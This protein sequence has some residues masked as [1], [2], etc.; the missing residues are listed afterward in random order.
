M[1]TQDLER[2]ELTSFPMPVTSEETPSDE[3]LLLMTEPVEEP[4]PY[5]EVLELRIASL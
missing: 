1:L 4:F 5:E 2:A 3:L